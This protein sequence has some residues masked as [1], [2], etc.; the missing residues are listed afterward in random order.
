MNCGSQIMSPLRGFGS[1]IHGFPG[2]DGP[3]Y[4][5]P[6]LAGAMRDST[7]IILVSARSLKRW[8]TPVADAAGSQK[9]FASAGG[10]FANRPLEQAPRDPSIS[11]RFRIP[12]EYCKKGSYNTRSKNLGLVFH[13]IHRGNRLRRV[14]FADRAEFWRVKIDFRKYAPKLR[15]LFASFPRKT[16]NDRASFVTSCVN[17]AAKTPRCTRRCGASSV[18]EN[19]ELTVLAAAL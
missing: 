17:R 16:A 18:A 9:R 14:L 8:R 5:M 3:G 6:P 13:N 2:P 4:S 12:A 15:A 11:R 7:C 1:W 19:D 10:S